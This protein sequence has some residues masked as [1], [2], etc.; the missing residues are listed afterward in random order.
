MFNEVLLLIL[1]V[2]IVLIPSLKLFC[3]FFHTFGTFAFILILFLVISCLKINKI[4]CVASVWFAGGLV[5]RAR[6]R[7]VKVRHCRRV[8]NNAGGSKDANLCHRRRREEA[9]RGA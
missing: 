2:I 1:S 8:H 7:W 4:L 6:R 9:G 3:G 5:W